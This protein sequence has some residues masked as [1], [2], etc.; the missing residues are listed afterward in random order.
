MKCAGHEPPTGEIRN[1]YKIL[2]GKPFPSTALIG[3][4]LKQNQNVFSLSL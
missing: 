4:S 1:V 2:V 3:W